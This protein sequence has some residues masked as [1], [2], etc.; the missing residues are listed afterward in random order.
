VQTLDGFEEKVPSAHRDVPHAGGEVIIQVILKA[1]EVAC[2][3]QKRYSFNQEGTDRCGDV[4]LYSC[5]RA[6][7]DSLVW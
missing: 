4:A 6:N 5:Y 3:N 1:Q 2:T 7:D